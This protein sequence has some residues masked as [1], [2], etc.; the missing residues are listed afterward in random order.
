MVAE[1]PKNR[2]SKDAKKASKEAIV[3]AKALS[4]RGRTFSFFFYPK[5]AMP[6]HKDG[7]AKPQ[8]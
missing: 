5:K 8:P 1:L 6:V 2:R 4:F 3:D 7:Y